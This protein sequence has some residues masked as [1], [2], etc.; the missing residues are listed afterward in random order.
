[1][2]I[3]HHEHH[4]L[5]ADHDTHEHDEH[6]LDNT[7]DEHRR[8]AAMQRIEVSVREHDTTLPDRM[9]QAVRTKMGRHKRLPPT[10]E[11]MM[12]ST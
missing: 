6:A 5:D 8:L 2:H 3:A 11:I 7:E 1:V 9:A 4:D 10:A 12:V